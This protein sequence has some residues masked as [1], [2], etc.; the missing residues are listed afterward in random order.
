MS[1]LAW[2]FEYKSWRNCVH[3]TWT[4]SEHLASLLPVSC[5]SEGSMKTST[6]T[7]KTNPRLTGSAYNDMVESHTLMITWFLCQKGRSINHSGCPLLPQRW[8]SWGSA[9]PEYT[10]LSYSE[11]RCKNVVYCSSSV[12]AKIRSCV[13]SSYASYVQNRAEN[14]VTSSYITSVENIYWRHS[15]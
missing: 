11:Q 3:K 5:S 12:L 8:H 10:V 7:K 2:H 9:S 6:L 4:D 1:L 14:C 15:R 13:T